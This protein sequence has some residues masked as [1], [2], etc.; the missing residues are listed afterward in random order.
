MS[1]SKDWVPGPDN[2]FFDFEDTLVTEV[3]AKVIPWNIDPLKLAPVQ[4]EK[5]IYDPLYNKIKNKATRN[6]TDITN[7]RIERKVYEKLIRTFAK[8]NLFYNSSMTEA[9]RQSIGIPPRDTIASPRPVISTD[10][11]VKIKF[12]SGARVVFECREEADQ[13]R[14][15]MHAD[16][17]EIEVVYQIGTPQPADPESCNKTVMSK[18]ARFTILAGI[19]NAGK[20]FFAFLRWRNS[21]EPQKSGPWTLI[22][23]G[24]IGE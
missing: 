4:A 1:K 7:H 2:E 14:P 5:V 13:T 17:D 22:V 9:D 19:S 20:K 18:K 16:A 21:S 23:Q 11:N 24:T 12:L 6:S 15:S 8:E 10:P 3:V